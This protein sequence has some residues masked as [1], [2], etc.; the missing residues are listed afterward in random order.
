[1]MTPCKAITTTPARS[2]ASQ[3]TTLGAPLT[4]SV[5]LIVARTPISAPTEISMLPEMIT[6][7]MPTAATAI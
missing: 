5:P 6:I 7:D 4:A 2:A 3:A 1:M